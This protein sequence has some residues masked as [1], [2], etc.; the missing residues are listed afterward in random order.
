MVEMVA[1]AEMEATEEIILAQ[2][3][4]VVMRALAELAEQEVLFMPVG[5]R[6]I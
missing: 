3:A 2:V 5:S 4:L 6:D 1:M